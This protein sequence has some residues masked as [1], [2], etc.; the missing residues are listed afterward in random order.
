VQEV[1]SLL[2]KAG[3][4]PKLFSATKT[5]LERGAPVQMPKP[6]EFP[7]IGYVERSE[8]GKLLE[9]LDDN[10]IQPAIESSSKDIQEWLTE[11]MAELRSWLEAS[12]KADRDLI[13]FY[14]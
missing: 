2:K 4:S 10:K 9:A 8:I 13:C 7:A 5:L 11:A 1:D 6:D 12:A 14:S 3:V